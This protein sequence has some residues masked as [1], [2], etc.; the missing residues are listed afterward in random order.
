MV[1]NRSDVNELLPSVREKVYPVVLSTG[2]SGEDVIL[3]DGQGPSTDDKIKTK[4]YTTTI[5]DIAKMNYAI[6]NKALAKNPVYKF[7]TLKSRFPNLKS[8]REFIT[9]DSYLGNIK[10][11]IRS[12]YDEP[13]IAILSSAVAIVIEKNCRNHL[14]Y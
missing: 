12:Q 1:K 9:S 7:N 10:M 5:G 4:L 13:P 14:I 2:Q 8:T 3:D 6:V 11:E